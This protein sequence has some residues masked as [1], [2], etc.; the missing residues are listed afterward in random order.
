[1]DKKQ[2]HQGRQEF[3]RDAAGVLQQEWQKY[4]LLKSCPVFFNITN[5]H[6]YNATHG[7][8]QGDLCLQHIEVILREVFPGRPVLHLGADNFVALADGVDVQERIDKACQRVQAFIGNP[9]VALKAGIRFLSDLSTLEELNSAFDSE[10]KIACDTIKKDA[11]RHWAIYTKELGLRHQMQ[12]YVREYLDEALEKG[13][14]HIYLQ[15]IIRTLTGKLVGA[16]AL[17]RW[18]SPQYG[19]I[20]PGIFIPVLEEARLIHKLDAY[21]LNAV[22]KRMRQTIDE[23]FPQLPISV[24]LSRL[25]FILQ[26]PVATAETIRKK[27]DLPLGLISIEVTENALVDKMEPVLDGIRRFQQGGYPVLLD[28]F[29]SGYSSLNVLKD[30]DFDTIKFDMKFLHPFTE[31]SRKILRALVSMAKDLSIH[32]LAEGAE[33]QEQCDFL[34]EIGCEKIQGYYYGKPI[35]SEDFHAYCLDKGLQLESRDDAKLF[36]MAGL[37]DLN[38]PIPISIVYDDTQEITMLHANRLYLQSLHSIGTPNLQRVNVNLRSKNYPMMEKFH[39]FSD[40]ILLTGQEESM[41]YVDNGQYMRLK[42]RAIAS[43][44]KKTAYQVGLYNISA[45][46]ELDDADSH[47]FDRL[48]R[49]LTLAYEAIWYCN[50]DEETIDIIEAMSTMRVGTRFNGV[51]AAMQNFASQ[52]VSPTDRE[53]FLAF[54]DRDSLYERASASHQSLIASAFRILRHDGHYDWIFFTCMALVKSNSHEMLI[55]LSK[56]LMGRQPNRQEI[57]RQ[58]IE[59]YGISKEFFAGGQAPMGNA[60][61]NVLLDEAGIEF[62][63]K[64]RQHRFRGASRAFLKGHGLQDASTI[65]GKT[66]EE[67]GWHLHTKAAYESEEQVM[68]T[69][70]PL[71]DVFEQ[72]NIGHRL[73]KVRASKYPLREGGKV[74]GVLIQ[75]ETLKDAPARQQSSIAMELIDKETHLLSYSGMIM[76]GLKYAAEYRLHGDDYTT[77]LLDVPEYD[78]IGTKYGQAFRQHLLQKVVTLL[79]QELPADCSVSRIG[80]CRFLIFA[81]K[82]QDPQLLQATLRI[83]TDVHAIEQVDGHPCTLFLH[84]AQ[85]HGSEI[86]SIGSLL[87]LLFKRLYGTV[88]HSND[89]L[90]FPRELFDELEFGVVINDPDTYEILYLNP[91]MRQELGMLPDAPLARKKCYE[92]MAGLNSPCENCYQARLC[93]NEALTDIYHNNVTSAD[94]LLCHTLVPWNGK[95]CHFCLCINLDYYM[96]RH[97]KHEKVL[98]EELSVNDL[99]RAGMYEIDPEHGIRKMM[100]RLGNLLSADRVLIAEEDTTMLHFPY[101]WTS[102]TT[103]PLAHEILP[104]ARTRLQPIYEKF[105]TQSV[106]TID[107][108]E[109]FSRDT[110]YAPHLPN[111][112]RLIFARLRLD[113]QIYGYIEVINPAPEKMEKAVPLMASLIRFFSIL[114]RNRNLMQ[115]IDRLSKVD[116]LTNIMNRR[117]LLDALKDLP[118]DRTY[119]FFFGD[120]NGLKETNDK[121]GHDA[122]DRLIQSAASTFVRA[123]PTDDVF[124]MGGDEFLMIQSVKN[125]QEASAISDALHDRFNAAGISISLGFSLATLPVANIDTVLAEADHRMY[126]EKIQHHKTRHQHQTTDV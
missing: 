59:S 115:S 101:V 23:G 22:A 36:D 68:R 63:W 117:G 18:E 126:K 118:A 19:T 120:L 85:V 17:A 53:R 106:F 32:T 30:Y 73:Q 41:T 93:H 12:N 125:K 71:L 81:K 11:S 84:Y 107:D 4:H 45:D 94:L 3:L 75:L 74:T 113:D 26:D 55:C 56:D 89:S 78:V 54:I 105:A 6:L 65:L 33:T 50:L 21:I 8:R 28:D 58:M 43:V 69:G 5:F 119:A 13:F 64:D 20:S 25:D 122:G 57:I 9:N 31:K 108:V 49:N 79:R 38:Q 123:C 86:R 104:F 39:R 67:L 103:L 72:L 60:I 96:Q 77:L 102:P 88:H 76:D 92:L 124:R 61:W 14:I 10:A 37:V 34:R 80:D 16:E 48:V 98:Y 121:L 70:E 15:P 66:D 51:A 47:L 27:Y 111:L 40:R 110:G 87:Q 109:Q 42:A 35:P 97:A 114:L 1:M 83:A 100:N 44:G 91:A 62:F 95:P 99:L 24:N 82:G 2:V 116:P 29:G 112:R 52:Y 7:F 46:Q 90:T